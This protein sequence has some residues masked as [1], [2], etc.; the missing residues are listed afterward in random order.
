MKSTAPTSIFRITRRRV[1]V[2]LTPS[3]APLPGIGHNQGPELDGTGLGHI[4]RRASKRA[5]RTP[6]REV[7]L[8]RLRRAELLGLSYREFTGVLMDR[9]QRLAAAVVVLAEPRRMAERGVRAKLDHLAAQRLLLCVPAGCAT[10]AIEATMIHRMN[11][12]EPSDAIAAAIARFCDA[13]GLAAASVFMVS[14]RES[15]LL[16]AE[17]AGL[18]LFKRAASFFAPPS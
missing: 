11:N 14:D 4:W 5:W 10:H 3:E 16:L 7:A 13:F 15:D 6:P 17:R 8:T 2:H 9:G 1:P 12:D 18:A